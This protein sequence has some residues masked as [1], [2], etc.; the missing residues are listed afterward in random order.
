MQGVL[1]I[2]F[3]IETSMYSLHVSQKKANIY[4]TLNILQQ[5]RSV[6]WD[7]SVKVQIE[8]STKMYNP[9]ED[10]RDLSR[11]YVLRI[12]SVS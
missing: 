2:I 3:L 12:P 6:Q 1:L 9:R 5:N 4:I 8:T 10:A 7:T 11:E